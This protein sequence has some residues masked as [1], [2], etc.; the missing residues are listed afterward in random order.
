MEIQINKPLAANSAADERDVSQLKRTLNRLGYYKP[1]EQTGITGVPDADLFA[2][3]KSFQKDRGL[4]ATGTLNPH[5]E[6]IQALNAESQKTPDGHYVWRTAGDDRVRATH[7]AHDWEIRTWNDSPHPGTEANCR[8]WADPATPEQEETKE[9]QKC[10]AN[11]PWEGDAKQNLK[12][13]EDDIES[14]YIDTAF[15][16]TIGIGINIDEKG[17]FINL[18]WRIGKEDGPNATQEQIEAAY[19]ALTQQKSNPENIKTT[20]ESGQKNGIFNVFAEKQE[21]WTD[22]KLPQETR[23]ELFSVAFNDFSDVLSAKKFADFECFPPMAKVALMDMIYNLGETK[24]SRNNWPNLF[25]AVNQRDW[26]EAA[27]QSNRKIPN[28]STGRNR[29]TFEQFIAAAE[30]EKESSP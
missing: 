3:L 17:K 23:D 22:F 19:D 25:K 16:I 27:K 6:T 18:P 9:K 4:R 20:E 7:A 30:M 5:D 13:H 1:Y 2:A 28:D 14:P 21:D 29:D 26:K 12:E 15:K 24:F 11:L 10:F 8:C